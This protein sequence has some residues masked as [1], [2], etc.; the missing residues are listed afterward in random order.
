MNIVPL[1]IRAR[2]MYTYWQKPRFRQTWQLKFSL[3]LSGVARTENESFP[4]QGGPMESSSNK[5]TFMY[6]FEKK[7]WDCIK[8]T[9][10]RLG[11]RHVMI[12][13]LLVD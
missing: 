1:T 7:V 10:T 5:Y 13:L 2:L 8:G 3:T 4:A 9:V 11:H 12:H 6:E